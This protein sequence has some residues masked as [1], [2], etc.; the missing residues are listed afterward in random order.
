M[1]QMVGRQFHYWRLGHD[2]RTLELES[3]GL[4]GR[5]AARCESFWWVDQGRLVLA[6]EN[7][8]VT[9]RLEPGPQGMWYGRWVNFERMPVL[10]VPE[11]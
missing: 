10:L 7:Q 6:D 4:I 8:I 9:A 5:G 2:D 1:A 3:D 11:E